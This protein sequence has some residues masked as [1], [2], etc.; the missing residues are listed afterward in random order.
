MRTFTAGFVVLLATAPLGA[1]APPDRIN[2]QG[3]LRDA[4]GNPLT[5][6]YDM[7]FRLY[8]QP[9][10]GNEILQ[11]RHLTVNGTP[12]GVTNGLFNV[13]IGSGQ[14]IDSAGAGYTTLGAA[15]R[16]YGS[17]WLDIQVGAE[18]LTPRLHVASAAY[19]LNAAYVGGRSPSDFLDTGPTAQAKSGQLSLT[20]SSVP[21]GQAPLISTGAIGARVE[22][23]LGAVVELGRY[24]DGLWATSAAGPTT[25]GVFY[26]WGGTAVN[27]LGAGT[28]GYFQDLDDSSWAYLANGEFGARIQGET[29]GA[30][31]QTPGAA[32]Y[33]WVAEPGF[34][35][36][37]KALASSA[38][39][40]TTAGGSFELRDPSGASTVASAVT[41]ARTPV[42]YGWAGYIDT[43]VGIKAFGEIGGVFVS[44][45]PGTYAWMASGSLGASAGGAYAGGLFQD[46]DSSSYAYVGS[47]TYKIQGSG[48]VAF[49]QN[50]PTDKDRVIVYNA[51]EGDEVATYTRGSARIA[52]GEARIPLGETFAWV[53]N[54]DLGLTA[55]VTPIGGWADLYVASKTT[56]ELV[57]RSRDPK[58]GPVEFDYIVYGLRIGFEETSI[59]QEKRDEAFI[60]SMADHRRRYEEHPELRR[61]SAMERV[62]G[63]RARM[64]LSGEPDLSASTALR[65][66]IHE[67]DDAADRER[68]AAANAGFGRGRLAPAGRSERA[69]LPEDDVVR[70]V[71]ASALV[72]PALAAGERPGLVPP[73]APKAPGA[74]S[75]PAA[76]SAF[77]PSGFAASPAEVLRVSEPVRGGELLAIDPQDPERVRRAE[78]VGDPRFVGV[79][80]ADSAGD[81]VALATT[82]IVRVLADGSFGAIAPGDLLTTSPSPGLAMRAVDP[83]PG[84]V[85]GRALDA[86]ESG[87]GEI[88]ALWM[89][90]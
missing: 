79:A 9:T 30:Y 38:A 44:D 69:S 26:S 60:P 67:Y 7:V 58:A 72:R 66:A 31:I 61:F 57:V 13:E 47:S 89:P 77:G 18:T 41:A 84:T 51:P 14:V 8:D 52:G 64:G 4:S 78:G 24:G 48:S 81:E 2:Y 49:A 27:A 75:P 62:K 37:T 42:D 80:G 33:A 23:T 28:G 40:A 39:Y 50:H 71:E 83:E 82:R 73:S 53:T 10:G 29:T 45:Q 59:V 35:I 11:D 12:V 86:L 56:K 22:S 85:F 74:I 15:F 20:G 55:Y 76:G 63:E 70:R 3:V 90:R 65:E 54:P 68:L 19:A 87:T 21:G 34:G 17:L 88:R 43:R 6:A 46:A 32:S 36:R 5:G 16:D 1:A 25:A